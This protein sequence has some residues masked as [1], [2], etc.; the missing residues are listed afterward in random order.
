VDL[1]AFDA[2]GKPLFNVNL[3]TTTPEEIVFQDL[4]PVHGDLV[5]SSLDAEREY[6][7]YYEV[8]DY[9]LAAH[10]FAIALEVHATGGHEPGARKVEFQGSRHSFQR[11]SIM[12]RR[13]FPFLRFPTFCGSCNKRSRRRNTKQGKPS[14]HFPMNL[15]PAGLGI[16]PLKLAEGVGFEPT[17]GFPTAVFKTAAIDRSTTPPGA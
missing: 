13:S 17:V 7:F 1:V 5:R 11:A 3:Q 10:L 8:T 9:R 2:A 12:A 4:R 15:F 6:F 14:A 16:I